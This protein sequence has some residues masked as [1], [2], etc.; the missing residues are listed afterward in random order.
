MNFKKILFST[1]A[2]TAAASLLFVTDASLAQAE[3][4]YDTEAAAIE[5]GEAQYG[6]GNV[7]ATMGADGKYYWTANPGATVVENEEEVV[8]NNETGFT[9]AEAAEEAAKV[10]LENDSV[11]NSFSVS[12]GANG[13]YF[14]ALSPVEA[15]EEVVENNE[16]G[17]TTAEAAEEA[18]K[19]ALENDPINNS[20]SVSQGA[21]GNYF[22]VLSPVEA[23]ETAEEEVVADNEINGY[24]TKEEAEAA[25]KKALENDPIN[26]SFTVAQGANGNYFY[27]LSPLE[28]EETSEK[29]EGKEESKGEKDSEEEAKKE[30]AKKEEA[31]KA[32]AVKEAKKE[33]AKKAAEAAPEKEAKAALPA[34]GA[35]ATP[36]ILGLALASVGSV[37][38]FGKKED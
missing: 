34:T 6:E 27:L 28:S 38:A 13:N 32:A 35:V 3:T 25:A 11:N 4:A 8:E 1:V 18:A 33:E 20:F 37:F 23:E 26:K 31:K 9:T 36:A 30:E 5:A 10:A 14:Y 22:Y 7:S 2:T 16:T 24:P 15:T 21:N 19:A 17:F 29:E 12:Q